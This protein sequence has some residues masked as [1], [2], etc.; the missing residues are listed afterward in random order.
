MFIMLYRSI[1]KDHNSFSRFLLS[2]FLFLF[3]S[4]VFKG[5]FQ[6]YRHNVQIIPYY[7]GSD[8]GISHL[9]M[10]KISIRHQHAKSQYY[11]Q[12]LVPYDRLIKCKSI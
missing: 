6:K 2:D 9:Q 12:T 11:T 7:V 10:L 4:K 5:L 8:L 3:Q 1:L